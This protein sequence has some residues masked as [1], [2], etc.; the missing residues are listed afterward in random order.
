LRNS[1]EYKSY[2]SIKE[3]SVEEDVEFCSWIYKNT[4]IASEAL[5]NAME[6]QNIWWAEALDLINSMVLKTIRVAHPGRKG[7]FELMPLFR[8]EEDDRDF[9]EKLFRETIKNDSY[10]ESLIAEKTKNWDVDRIALNGYYF[11]ENG[12]LRNT[13]LRWNPN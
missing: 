12:T 11:V 6:E 7:Q 13:H 5:Q 3:H 8:D 10:F 9:M 1:A 2:V 4:I